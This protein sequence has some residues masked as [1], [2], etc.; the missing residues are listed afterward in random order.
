VVAVGVA[1][2]LAGAARARAE[3][4]VVLNKSANTATFV[5]PATARV[6]G[7]APTG[8]GPHEGIASADGSAVYVSDYGTDAAPGRSITVLDGPGRRVRATWGL[9]RHTRPHGLALSRDGAWLW[10]TAEG[11][12]RGARDRDRQRPHRAPLE[13]RAGGL[14]HGRAQPRRARALDR[15]PGLGDGD[16]H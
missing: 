11:S 6:L 8:A 12:G 3:T 13:D 14:P 10:V 2:A 16:G 15:Q 1:V 9:G 4:L 5:D 7:R